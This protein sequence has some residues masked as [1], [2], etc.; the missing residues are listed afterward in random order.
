[1]GWPDMVQRCKAVLVRDPRANVH[2]LHRITGIEY[3]ALG[4]AAHWAKLELEM[5]LV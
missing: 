2:K 3:E 4:L 1:M 5:G